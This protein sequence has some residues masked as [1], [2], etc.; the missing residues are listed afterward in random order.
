MGGV[1]LII[2]IDRNDIIAKAEIKIEENILEMSYPSN[3]NYNNWDNLAKQ[4][5]DKVKKN[6]DSKANIYIIMVKVDSNNSEEYEVK[7][8]GKSKAIRSR[9][10]EHLVKC[11][12]GTSSCLSYVKDNIIKGN[13]KN[14]Y[15]S[16]IEII[17]KEL[18]SYIETLLLNEYKSDNVWYS[19]DS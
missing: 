16:T 4:S 13:D 2:E 18:N 11:S 19:R 12:V 5:Y 15:I 14:I 8:I 9:V 1:K 7:Y 10:R 17:P 3:I 6:I